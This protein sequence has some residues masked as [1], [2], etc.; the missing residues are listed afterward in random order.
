MLG[1]IRLAWWRERLQALDSGEPAPPEPRLRAVVDTLLPIGVS[2]HELAELEDGWLRLFDPLPWSAV[3]AA[4]IS[5]RGATLFAL[6]GKVLGPAN[7]ALA[8]AGSMWSLV[9]AARHC[10]DPPSRTI[11][12]QAATEVASILAQV[13]FPLGVRPVSMLAAVMA[14][15]LR[16]GEPFEREGTPARAVALLRHRMTGR[17]AIR[18]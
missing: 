3:T 4:A 2:G 10:S 9:D 6:A 13:R 16:N 8:V 18:S 12:V 1:Q 7:E 5:A 17:L 15:D 11:L 14:R